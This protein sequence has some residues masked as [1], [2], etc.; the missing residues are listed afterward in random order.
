VLAR[1]DRALRV[2][3]QVIV[4][5]N[6]IDQKF[7]TYGEG[8][9]VV[10]DPDTDTVTA[11][12]ALTGLANCEG[13]TYV[14]AHD[15]LLVA[16]GGPFAGST[17]Q[18]GLAVVDVSVSPPV[19]ARVVPS[20]AFD[21]RPLDMGWV[22]EAPAAAGGTSAFAVTNDPNDVGP[23]ALFL[24]DYVAGTTQPVATS[25]PYTFGTPVGLA[26][27]LLVPNATRAA[28]RIDRFDLTAAPAPA[29]SLTSDPV[30]N[31][32]PQSMAPY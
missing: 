29:G 13:M 15:L 6:E 27:L 21:G 22:L 16:C 5:L 26:G 20:A 25:G 3:G 7:A 24:L 10:V 11:A 9:L 1:P 31:L 14:A 19:L 23:D 8:K 18:S 28:P 30:T 32:P 12:V 4:S 2:D 17:A